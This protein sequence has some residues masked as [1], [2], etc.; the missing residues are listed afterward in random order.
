LSD[1]IWLM[2]KLLPF[3]LLFMVGCSPKEDA[4]PPP[5]PTKPTTMNSPSGGIAPIGSGAAAGLT[6]VSGTENLGGG[7]GGGIAS[8]A[9]GQAMSAAAAAG[10]GS[11]AQMTQ[12]DGQ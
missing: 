2:R 5:D 6:P 3:T 11:A 4:P 9:K 10:G 12:V 8:A 1:N 7:T